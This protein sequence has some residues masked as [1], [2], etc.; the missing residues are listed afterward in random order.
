MKRRMVPSF[1]Q[2]AF[3]SSRP[4]PGV[5]WEAARY[6]SHGS[7]SEGQC[8]DAGLWHRLARTLRFGKSEGGPNLSPLQ[9]RHQKSSEAH[10]GRWSCISQIALSRHM[11]C[12]VTAPAAA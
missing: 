7:G 1:S 4:R 6:D 12:K 11:T 10:P 8:C 9:A 2:A 5:A 3:Q